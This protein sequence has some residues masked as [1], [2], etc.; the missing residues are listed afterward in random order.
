MS[1]N[2]GELANGRA[3]APV[4]HAVQTK[5]SQLLQQRGRAKRVHRIHMDRQ[6]DCEESGTRD[7]CTGWSAARRPL[8]DVHALA[9]LATASRPRC[10]L[11][12]ARVLAR[13]RGPAAISFRLSRS[14]ILKVGA[15]DRYYFL[16]ERLLRVREQMT[17][18]L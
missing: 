17:D 8:D 10:G 13:G 11:A 15:R 1:A 4:M 16:R 6:H 14:R 12:L 3:N 18:F 5:G 9:A 2:A 7:T